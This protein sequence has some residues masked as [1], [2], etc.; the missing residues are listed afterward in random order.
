[1]TEKVLFWGRI[2]KLYIFK[3]WSRGEG[4]KTETGVNMDTPSEV[5]IGDV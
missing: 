1:M 5:A 3:F 4:V 2:S